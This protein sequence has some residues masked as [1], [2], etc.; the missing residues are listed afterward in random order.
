[1]GAV[2]VER[3]PVNLEGALG[4][5]V[6]LSGAQG[7]VGRVWDKKQENLRVLLLE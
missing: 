7:P 4:A 1:M 6:A 5:E 3:W 2:S